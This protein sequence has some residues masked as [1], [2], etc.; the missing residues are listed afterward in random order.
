MGRGQAE[1]LFYGE[2]FT[3][4]P[5]Q[6]AT[7]PA[8]EKSELEI[9]LQELRD[10]IFGNSRYQ[11]VKSILWSGEDN[12]F[13]DLFLSMSVVFDVDNKKVRFVVAVLDS[14]HERPP[15]TLYEGER[16]ESALAEGAAQADFWADAS[17]FDVSEET[18]TERLK[19]IYRGRAYL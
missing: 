19:D 10:Y 4:L 14:S 15:Y 8:E 7:A 17:C 3:S 1:E 13:G 18:V 12:A 16:L 5:E 6:K 9:S 11:T 2:G